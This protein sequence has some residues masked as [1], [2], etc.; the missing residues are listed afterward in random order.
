[1]APTTLPRT[2]SRIDNDLAALAQEISEDEGIGMAT[3][4]VLA[5][6]YR[7]GLRDYATDWDAW[8]TRARE[9]MTACPVCRAEL[10]VRQ[11]YVGG[12]GYQFVKLCSCEPRHYSKAA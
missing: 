8:A 1:M 5:A 9:A 3:A 7:D 4:L 6:L 12:R 10:E 11:Y 2:A